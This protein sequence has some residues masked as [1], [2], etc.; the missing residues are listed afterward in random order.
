MN[1]QVGYSLLRL[2]FRGCRREGGSVGPHGPTLRSRIG[3]E[4][5][6]QSPPPL[7]CPSSH[8]GSALC[9]SGVSGALVL[10]ALRLRGSGPESQLKLRQQRFLILFWTQNVL[11]LFFANLPPPPRWASLI[12]FSLQISTLQRAPA[13]SIFFTDGA[14]LATLFRA[15]RWGLEGEVVKTQQI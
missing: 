1:E 7:L 10:P 15:P 4:T 12:H 9:N 13:T 3:S 11:K 14:V 5:C 8:P 2:L 6:C